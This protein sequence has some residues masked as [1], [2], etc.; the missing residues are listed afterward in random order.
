MD[1]GFET[2]IV[3]NPAIGAVGLWGF[4]RAYFDSRDQT[5]GP[6]LPMLMLVLP[7]AFHMRSAVALERMK[8]TS[9]LAKAM[10]DEPE[11]PVGLQAR[12][13]GLADSSLSS[14]SV[15]TASKLL[16][17]D[18]D[19]PWPRFVPLR[20]TVPGGLKPQSLESR[21]I[22]AAAKRLGWWFAQ[23]DLD[24]VCAVLRVRF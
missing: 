14:L 24:S 9:G 11:M 2:A 6:S 15:A 8:S 21:R 1:L 18:P 5:D 12:L 3:H 19:T 20:K 13:E 4:S 22:L 17:I 16:G 10:L 23:D 7:I